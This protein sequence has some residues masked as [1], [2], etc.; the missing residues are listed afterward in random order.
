MT[1]PHGVDRA[2]VAAFP[3]L[4]H[5]AAI[6]DRGWRFTMPMHDDHGNVVAIDGFRVWPGG[7]SDAIRIR[8]ATNVVGLR[9]FDDRPPTITWE[10]YG[11]LR[12]VTGELLDLPVPDARFAPRLVVGHAPLWTPGCGW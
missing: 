2:A 6:R 12:T 10:Y 1:A 9:C 8:S 3:E 11:D 5:L 7:W 4:D